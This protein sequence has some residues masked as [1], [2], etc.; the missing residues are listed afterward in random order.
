M[1]HESMEEEILHQLVIDPM[2][3]P[4][5]VFH[6]YHQSI[7]AQKTGRLS[8]CLTRVFLNTQVPQRFFCTKQEPMIG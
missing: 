7:C 6:S 2:I 5:T 1:G 4:L 8:R 3:I